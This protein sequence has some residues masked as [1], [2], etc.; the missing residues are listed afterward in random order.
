MEQLTYNNDLY[1]SPYIVW[2]IRS[3]RMRW[4]GNVARRGE[5][6]GLYRVLMGTPVGKKPFVW[7]GKSVAPTGV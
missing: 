3:R 6:R 4:A 1:S 2:V 5:R 7:K